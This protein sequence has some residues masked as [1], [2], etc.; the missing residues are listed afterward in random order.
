MKTAAIM[1]PTYL[2]WLGY[3]YLMD[4]S[5]YFVFLDSVQFEKRSWQ[6]RN[7]IKTPK[8]DLLLTV[9]VLSKGR[10]EQKINEVKIDKTA[11]FQKKHL[12]AIKQNYS[13][14]KFFKKYITDLEKILCRNH[15]YLVDLNEELISW[16]KDAIGIKSKLI[17]SSSLRPEGRK[18]EPLV[19]I[20]KSIGAK[21]YL[22]PLGSKTYIDKNNL[23]P[24]Y[25]IELIYNQYQ[26]PRYRQL[27][28]NFIPNLSV[29]DLLF[30]EGDKSLSIIKSGGKV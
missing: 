9:P 1:Q 28:G 14:A 16:L 22:S 10:F 29:I 6:Q 19:S 30:N 25:E 24:K 4:Q 21:R 2:P 3:F 12:K 15:T 11:E 23:F 5:D 26:H 7:K 17:R 8:G 20:C 27:Y 13:Q 18:V